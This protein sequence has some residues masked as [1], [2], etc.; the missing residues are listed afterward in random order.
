LNAKYYTSERTLYKTTV[1]QF[2]YKVR[3]LLV[4]VPRLTKYNAMK[5]LLPPFIALLATFGLGIGVTMYLRHRHRQTNQPWAANPPWAANLCRDGLAL[6][7]NTSEPTLKITLL[8]TSCEQQVASVH[9][10]VTNVGTAPI[11]YFNVRAIYTYDNY[12]DDGSEFG[13]G[14]LMTNQSTEGFIGHGPM[15]FGNGKQV[16]QLRGMTLIPSL[17]EFEDGRKWRRPSMYEPKPK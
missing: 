4:W 15:R 11:K 6:V 10:A 8:E 9:F 2:N 5:K 1:R 17:L 12:V 7:D 13:T 14:P 16:G 3:Q